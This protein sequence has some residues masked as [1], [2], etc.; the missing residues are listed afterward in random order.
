MSLFYSPIVFKKA[1][2]SFGPKVCFTDFSAVIEPGARIGLIGCNGCGK[3]SLLKIFTSALELSEGEVRFPEDASIGYVPQVSSY[4]LTDVLSGGQQFNALLSR[5]LTGS[6]NVLV[7]DEPTNHLDRHNRLS[8]L[9]FLSK[10]KGTLLVASHDVELLSTQ[11]DVLWDFQNEQIEVFH[12][13]YINLC[14]CKAREKDQFV[15]ER[16]RIKDQQFKFKADLE[17]ERH[18]Q[19]QSRKANRKENDKN[20]LGYLKQKG[21]ST[22]GRNF[23]RLNAKVDAL[24]K[25]LEQVRVENISVVNFKLPSLIALK[26]RVL[27]VTNGSV[28]YG[29]A[30][31][32]SNLF[33]IADYGDRIAIVGNNGCGKSTLVCALLNDPRVQYSGEWTLPKAEEIGL[34][35]QNYHS[36]PQALTVMEAYEEAAPK[37]TVN[38][39][40]KELSTFLFK[41]NASVKTRVSELSGGEKVRL[42]IA[43]CSTKPLRLLILDEPTNN[44]DLDTRN[45]LVSAL[46]NYSGTLIVISHDE[47]FLKEVGVNK[48]WRIESGQVFDRNLAT[49]PLL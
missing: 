48:E 17:A 2:L 11:V 29:D 38:E 18:R 20:L 31:V 49:N 14:E 6:P 44:L 7:L 16:Q 25:E 15:K 33:L 4:S 22:A 46:K 36:L 26:G 23:A 45:Y 41:K 19:S 9:R 39:I 10:W 12:G 8:L 42:A 28:S 37:L 32:L 1:G 30:R 5:A 40:R 21:N 34:L 24:S 35:D 47:S 3:S 43:L 27:Q 13:N